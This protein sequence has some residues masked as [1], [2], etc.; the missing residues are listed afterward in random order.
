[1]DAARRAVRIGFDVLEIQSAHG[2]LLHE[3]LSPHSNRRE[4]SYGGS[5]EARRKYPLEVFE[6]V[7]AAWPSDKAL[8][9]RVSATDYIPDGLP[10]EDVC[11]FVA[12]LRDRGCDFVDVSGGGVA[13]AQ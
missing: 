8:G 5:A 1:M 12:A 4:D 3:F 11:D 10:I 7:R 6:A 9:I 13:A 2:Y